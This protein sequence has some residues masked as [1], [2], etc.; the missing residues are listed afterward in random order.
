MNRPPLPPTLAVEWEHDETRD[1]VKAGGMI[2]AGAWCLILDV[3]PLPTIADVKNGFV[4]YLG[5][6][7]LGLTAYPVRRCP[8]PPR[9]F[10]ACPV[11]GDAA[12][13]VDGLVAT[14]LRA[15]EKWCRSEVCPGSGKPHHVTGV[16]QSVIDAL[17]AEEKPRPSDES[18]IDISVDG[19]AQRFALSDFVTDAAQR[20]IRELEGVANV[21]RRKLK[22]AGE[23]QKKHIDALEAMDQARQAERERAEV[24]ETNFRNTAE[25]LKA[26]MA[27]AKGAESELEA[28][29]KDPFGNKA[30]LRKVIDQLQA[31][32]DVARLK[33]EARQNADAATTERRWK[34]DVVSLE[35]IKA[36]EAELAEARSMM[37]AQ[38]ASWYRVDAERE[39]AMAQRDALASQLQAI[40]AAVGVRS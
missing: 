18:Y 31:E 22:T 33:L 26:E 27:R 32:R 38:N 17:S 10:V 9:P 23:H 5:E 39:A 19:V 11:C 35:R 7:A 4:V 2:A 34:E 20:R 25:T 29:T 1:P 12:H 40:R 16:R 15:S 3:P 8:S 21:L 24:A 37:A 14:H 36:L 6:V 13:I 30:H 28:A